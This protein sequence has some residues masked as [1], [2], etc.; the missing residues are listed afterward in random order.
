M[1]SKWEL[2]EELLKKY[3]QRQPQPLIALDADEGE[4]FNGNYSINS[5]WELTDAAEVRVL[6]RPGVSLEKA[7]RLME[8]L[9]NWIGETPGFYECAERCARGM[10][11]LRDANWPDSESRVKRETR[12]DEYKKLLA[13]VMGEAQAT[14]YFR[15]NSRT[16]TEEDAEAYREAEKELDAQAALLRQL[17]AREKLNVYSQTFAEIRNIIN[18]HPDAIHGKDAVFSILDDL[19]ASIQ[20]D[21]VRTEGA[22]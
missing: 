16:I 19:L 21:V 7:L 2:K 11:E 17:V 18:E 12:L 8:G 6:I 10:R 9:S 3:A 4:G 1:T 13:E 20:D 5:S 14:S 22:A 15:I